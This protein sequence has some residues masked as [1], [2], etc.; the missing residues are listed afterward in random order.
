MPA[1]VRIG[2]AAP[3]SGPQAIVGVPMGEVVRLA[4]SELAPP[5]LD[6]ELVACDDRAD[7]ASAVLA[8][9]TLV[10]DS[11]VVAVVGHKNSGA[12]AAAGPL[13]HR[14]GLTQLTQSATDSS[15]SRRGWPTFFRLCADNER[16]AAVAAEFAVGELGSFRPAVVHDGT[17]YG[18]PLGA[19]F[20]DRARELDVEPVAHLAVRVGQED[21]AGVVELLRN[22]GADLVYVG[23]TEV[24]GSKLTVALRRAGH[25]ARIMTAEGGPANPF[26]HLAGAAAEGSVHTYAGFDAAS[27]GEGRSLAGRCAAFGGLP[28]YGVECHDAVRVIAA[29]LESGARTRDEVRSAVVGIDVVGVSGRIRFLPGGERE[30]A[31][32][33]LWRVE[34]GRMVR[35][36]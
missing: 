11:G 2:Y 14:A 4:V 27:S 33:S 32:V 29:A 30:G 20:A 15:L 26:P 18:Q 17:A 34:S 10:A 23:A 19:A 8:A 16:Q 22:A 13:Y 25:L 36:S 28:S 1:A 9:K 3:L 12:C 21:F 5:R 31:P 35:L 24:E 6:L 7:D